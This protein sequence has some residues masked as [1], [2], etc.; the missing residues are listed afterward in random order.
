MMQQSFPIKEVSVRRYVIRLLC[1]L[2]SSCITGR[3]FTQLQPVTPDTLFRFVVIGDNRGQSDGSQHPVF[4]KMV[5]T[6]KELKAH[7]VFNTG[8]LIDGYAGSSEELLLKQWKGYQEAIA[9]LNTPVFHAPGNHD[10]FDTLSARIWK[11]LLGPTY[12]SFDH[13]NSRFIILDTETEK[14]RIAGAQFKWLIRQLATARNRNVFL[15]LHRPLF[16]VDGH[17]GS[18]LDEFPSERD[19]LHRLFVQHRRRIKAVFVGHEHLYNHQQRDGIE[20]YITGGGGANLYEPR[21]LGGFYHFLV[22]SV[23]A[24]KIDVKVWTPDAPSAKKPVLQI[25]PDS[26]LESWETPL[27]WYT[28]DQ[29]VSGEITQEEAATG[30]RGLKLCFNTSIYNWPVLYTPFL[31]SVN[32][33]GVDMLLV[34]VFVPPNSTSDVS[35]TPTIISGNDY[36]APSVSLRPGWNTVKTTLDESWL[37]QNARRGVEQIKW[38]ISSSD[39]NSAACLIFDNFRASNEKSNKLSS[40]SSGRQSQSSVTSAE[41]HED[42]EYDL[43][44][45]VSNENV[46]L[47]STTE[48]VMNGKRGLKVHFDFT[49]SKSMI[50]YARMSSSWDLR[51]VKNLRLDVYVPVTVGNSVEVDLILNH[52]GR[53]YR[54]PSSALKAGWNTLRF[55]LDEKRVPITAKQNVE[56]IRFGISSKKKDLS[57]W[58]V[59]DN[60]RSDSRWTK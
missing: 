13:G 5:H 11:K 16:P 36:T 3:A 4:L 8:D 17:I 29:S 39:K 44:W 59:F 31:H 7:F 55:Y 18:S 35:I 53:E 60:L 34:D 21:E 32:M 26:L 43:T 15:F 58:V 46:G 51:R 47:E 14:S 37:P 1:I 27:F 56:Q 23:K 2:C 50:L 30:T 38:V 12:Y 49:N 41:L 19:R 24:E 22:V 40:D 54:T 6:M 33:L 42:W 25:E 57:G 48:W 10:I 9:V 45:G 28:W 52:D 20:Y